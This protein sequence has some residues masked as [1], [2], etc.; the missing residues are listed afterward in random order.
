[1]HCVLFLLIDRL[2]CGLGTLIGRVYAYVR[3]CRVLREKETL[4][5]VKWATSVFRW[6]YKSIVA[7]IISM[8]GHAKCRVLGGQVATHVKVDE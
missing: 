5:R 7:L 8:H 4:D 3:L 6:L 2:D 1:M